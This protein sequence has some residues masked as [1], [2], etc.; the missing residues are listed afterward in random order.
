LIRRWNLT[1]AHGECFLR[2]SRGEA[3]GDRDG[4]G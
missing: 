2:V 1:S 4:P 3:F